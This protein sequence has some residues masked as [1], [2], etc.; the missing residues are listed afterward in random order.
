[1]AEMGNMPGPVRASL[2]RGGEPGWWLSRSGLWERESQQGAQGSS[3]C[4]V[5]GTPSVSLGCRGDRAESTCPALEGQGWLGHMGQ[6]SVVTNHVNS[7]DGPS[8]IY[9]S[10]G[11]NRG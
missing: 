8:S 7:S 6:A 9:G 10:Q 2:G 1:M 4:G 5:P 11:C 3:S